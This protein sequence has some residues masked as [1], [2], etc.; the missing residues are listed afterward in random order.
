MIRRQM[1]GASP[2]WVIGIAMMF[3]SGLL[4]RDGDHWIILVLSAIILAIDGGIL[5]LFEGKRNFFEVILSGAVAV[6]AVVG[7]V[8]SVG[9]SFAA[10]HVFLILA[11]V[12]SILLIIEGFRRELSGP[13]AE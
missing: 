3:A 8:E 13:G 12:G 5:R 11:L 2:M 7:L 6:T 4:M 10:K 1:W 9:K